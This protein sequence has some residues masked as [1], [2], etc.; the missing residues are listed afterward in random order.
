MGLASIAT[1][2]GLYIIVMKYPSNDGMLR[3]VVMWASYRG[4]Q[5][6]IEC[7][8]IKL[9][10]LRTAFEKFSVTRLNSSELLIEAEMN[11]YRRQ[12][13][14]RFILL[15]GD[16]YAIILEIVQSGRRKSVV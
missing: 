13:D 8:P 3:S 14:V 4:D 1:L 15:E 11:S 6:G 2:F 12:R 9:A 7:L 10:A 16:T 5:N